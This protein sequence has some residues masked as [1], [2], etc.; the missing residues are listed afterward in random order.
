M[1]AFR[2]TLDFVKVLGESRECRDGFHATSTSLSRRFSLQ[3]FRHYR[4]GSGMA[5][6]R[7]GWPARPCSS[8]KNC[9][10][11]KRANRLTQPNFMSQQDCERF[12]EKTAEL[13][14][15]LLLEDLQRGRL[16]FSEE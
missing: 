1:E 3:I 14:S 4:R 12:Q 13:D 10:Q 8:P 15:L 6:S 7:H 2:A 16:R 9:S 11:P 5:R